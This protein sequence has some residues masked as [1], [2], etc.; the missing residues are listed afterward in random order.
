MD[1]TRRGSARSARHLKRGRPRDVAGRPPPSDDRRADRPT[2]GR[3]VGAGNRLQ[4]AVP[5]SVSTLWALAD[6]YGRGDVAGTIWEA[7]HGAS[8]A[9]LEYLERHACTSRAGRGGHLRLRGEGFIG[10]VFPHRFSREGDPQIHVHVLAVNTTMAGDPAQEVDAAWRTLDARDLYQH[11]LAAGYLFQAELRRRLTESLG[12]SWT[13]VHKG[14]AE[15]DGVPRSLALA[16]SQRR[17]QIMRE[18]GVD[19]RRGSAREAEI[20]A[21][22]TRKAKQNFDLPAQRE[23]WRTLAIEHGFGPDEFAAALSR[24]EFA[25]L[26]RVET[27]MA[28]ESVIEPNGLMRDRSTFARRDVVRE[29]AA[30]HGRGGSV[31]RIEELADRLIDSDQIVTLDTSEDRVS[32]AR[33]PARPPWSG[34]VLL[35]TP[36]ILAVEAKMLDEATGRRA[37]GA[38]VVGLSQSSDIE[39]RPTGLVLSDDQRDA[40]L[41]LVTSGAGVEVLRAKAGTGKTTAIDAARQLWQDAGYRVIGAA[42]AGRAADELR[43]RAGI[44]SWTVHGLLL[45]LDR[46]GDW[47]LDPNTVLVVDEAGMVDTRRL[48]ARA[49][50]RRACQGRVGWRRAP[51]PCRR[52]RRGVRRT[53]RPTRGD[54]ADPGPPPTARVGSRCSRP[55]PPR[56]HLRVGRCLRTARPSRPDRRRRRP[57]PNARRGLVRRSPGPRFRTGDHARPEARRSRGS[58][59]ARTRRSRRRRRVG[60]QQRDGRRRS[61]IRARRPDNGVAKP[62]G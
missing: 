44:E 56:R 11:K 32:L 43:A 10:A 26:T 18:L 40:V 16:L 24:V 55:P 19:G 38:G 20:A 47:A 33:L 37:A 15:I 51:G 62:V 5:K 17:L 54:R 48:A 41:Q 12:V 30:E 23:H 42:L 58:Q 1:R 9:T 3:K 28:T 60:R 7:T 2:A 46:R 52:G 14:S 8:S 57:G 59:P 13:D 61:P 21:L 35:T 22:K 53:R 6:D 45:D 50:R 31:A 39:R 49:R 4:M 29:L 34:E 27:L 25:E 36:D